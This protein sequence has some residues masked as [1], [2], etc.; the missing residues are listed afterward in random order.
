[1]RD[2]YREAG[3][4]LDG[5]DVMHRLSPAERVARAQVL[6]ALAQAEAS[7]ATVEVLTRIADALDRGHRAS[8][9]GPIARPARTVPRRGPPR[10]RTASRVV[11]HSGQGRR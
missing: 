4:L 1:M 11:P 3:E 7:R 6:A 10:V 8:A 9:A 5:L 2:H